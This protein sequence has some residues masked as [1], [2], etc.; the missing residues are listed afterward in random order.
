MLGSLLWACLPGP[1]L[2]IRY[3]WSGRSEKLEDLLRVVWHIHPEAHLIRVE[4]I[5]QVIDAWH[6]VQIGPLLTTANNHCRPKVRARYLDFLESVWPNNLFSEEFRQSS[7]HALSDR[8][9]ALLALFFCLD[10]RSA[11]LKLAV[12]H[13]Q[14]VATL[15]RYLVAEPG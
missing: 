11:R 8:H 2:R 13:D 1:A 10:F 6:V 5:Q 12:F 3:A 9:C 4:F 14:P 15:Q 7:K